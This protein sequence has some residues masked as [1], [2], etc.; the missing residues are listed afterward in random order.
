MNYLELVNNVLVRLREAEV[1]A[2]T[3][4][5]YSKLIGTFV[6]DAKRL[7]EDSFQWNVLTE[8][9]TVTTAPDLFNY[10]LTGSGQR[11]RVM[12][13]VHSSGD[14]FLT[15]KTSSQMNQ[16][17]L[18][19]VPQKGDSTFYNF[20]GV[21]VNGDTQV[22]LY[23]I[24]NGI[25]TIFFNLYKPQ[26]TLTDASTILFVPSEPVL[27]YAY[28]MAVAE[29]GEDGGLSAQEATTVALSSLSDHIAMAESRQNDQ[30]IWA[31]V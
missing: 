16:F 25:Q 30:Y 9:L 24:P 13:V 6:N 17:L 20:N 18:N 5:P 22:D 19:G 29:R 28:A 8:T 15:P 11:F 21:D 3:D 27:K 14:Y 1:T 10:V 23:P 7:V 2:P 31:A 26:P 12:D 4:T